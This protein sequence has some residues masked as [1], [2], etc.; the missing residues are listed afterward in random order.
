MRLTIIMILTMGLLLGCETSETDATQDLGTIKA[1]V[2]E[3]TG[4]V[5]VKEKEDVKKVE[6]SGVED[7]EAVV[8]GSY[9]AGPYGKTP[10]SVIDNHRFKNPNTGMIVELKDFYKEGEVILINASSGWCSVCKAEVGELNKLYDKYHAQG[11]DVVYTLFED[12]YSNPPTDAY[13]KSWQST[14]KAKFDIL[15]DSNFELGVYF[16]KSAT[17]MNM[18]VRTKDMKIIYLSVGFDQMTIESKIQSLVQ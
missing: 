11:F 1:E 13:A 10:G 7:K 2:V 14:Y 5:D 12:Q 16:D 15:I 8:D 6:D 4:V 18:L 17:P 3:D 9:P